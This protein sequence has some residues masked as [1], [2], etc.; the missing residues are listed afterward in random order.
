[1]K[2]IRHV[3]LDKNESSTVLNLFENN[4]KWFKKIMD[5]L[6]S[7]NNRYLDFEFVFL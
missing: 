1:M 6:N 7:K 4:Q 3:L 2:I 5:E